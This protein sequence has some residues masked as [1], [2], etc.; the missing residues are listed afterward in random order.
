MIKP[1]GCLDLKMQ[2]SHETDTSTH[3]G[4]DTLELD[5]PSSHASVVLYLLAFII[6]TDIFPADNLTCQ[7]GINNKISAP[8]SYFYALLCTT[9]STSFNAVLK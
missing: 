4:D 7:T 6:D 8:V 2:Q 3:T 5:W 9:T 1:G